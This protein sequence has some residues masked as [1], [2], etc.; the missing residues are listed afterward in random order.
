MIP[1]YFDELAL[2]LKACASLRPDAC[3]P[4]DLRQLMA[5]RLT[6]TNYSL[7]EKVKAFDAVQMLALSA[8]VYQ[9]QALVGMAARDGS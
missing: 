5:D 1:I 2:V 9:A 3:S 6:H 7:A 8:F 4:A